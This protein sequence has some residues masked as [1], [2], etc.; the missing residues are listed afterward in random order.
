MEGVGDYTNNQA[1]LHTVEGCSISST[2]SSTLGIT[3]TVVTNTDCVST[4]GGCGIRSNST[5]SY[6]AAFN[7]NGGGVFTSTLVS[8][9]CSSTTQRVLACSDAQFVRNSSLVL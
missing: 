6:G 7:S 1:T 4:G 8:F 3:G 5:V 2:S 9:Y